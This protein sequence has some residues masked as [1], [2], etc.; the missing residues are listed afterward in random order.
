MGAYGMAQDF[1]KYFHLENHEFFVTVFFIFLYLLLMVILMIINTLYFKNDSSDIYK[2]YRNS[3]RELFAETDKLKK[4]LKDF[5]KMANELNKIIVHITASIEARKQIVE[6]LQLKINSLSTEESN[7]NEKLNTL[8]EFSNKQIVVND[9]I[10]D[11]FKRN[12]KRLILLNII[13]GFVF[14]LLGYTLSK[15]F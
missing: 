9:I 2:F 8:N 6:I 12:Y 11:F 14:C 10:N 4:M 13:I 3:S 15:G 7:L 5:N 1:I